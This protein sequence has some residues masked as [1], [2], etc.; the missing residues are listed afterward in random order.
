MPNEKSPREKVFIE[1]VN[2]GK[3]RVTS[4][5]I[6]LFGKRFA[7][8]GVDIRKINTREQAWH[9][10]DLLFEKEMRAFAQTDAGKDPMLRDL[11]A[12]MPGW[13]DLE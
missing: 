8:V 10:V 5:G 11:F 6:A 13:E 1:D 9:A 2:T 3:I 7:E 12:G 4:K